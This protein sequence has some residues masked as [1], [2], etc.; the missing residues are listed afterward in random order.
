MDERSGAGIDNS[1]VDIEAD[2]CNTFLL[3][4]GRDLVA[5][6]DKVGGDVA[7]GPADAR[8]ELGLVE[9][10]EWDVEEKTSVTSDA[11]SYSPHSR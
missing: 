3:D 10:K 5:S 8:T 6:A 7:D 2:P 9:V 4:S 11:M 1:A